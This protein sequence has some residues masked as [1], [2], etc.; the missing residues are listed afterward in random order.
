M[1]KLLLIPIIALFTGC[2]T[3]DPGADPVAVNAEKTTQVAYDVFNTFVHLEYDHKSDFAQIGKG[4]HQ[5]ANQIRLHGRDW[6]KTA[7]ALT[8]TYEANRTPENKANLL[9]SIAVIQ[10]AMTEAQKYIAQY[11]TV[12]RNP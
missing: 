10:S 8:N 5:I 11:H 12:T 2:V 6:L 4:P 9:T 7:R 1:K 3:L